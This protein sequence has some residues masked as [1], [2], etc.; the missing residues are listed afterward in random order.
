V[1]LGALRAAGGALFWLEV[2]PL[3]GGRTTLVRGTLDGDVRDVTPAGTN[4]RTLV[5][6]YG[7][8]AYTLHEHADG[9]VTVFYSEFSDQR[10]YRLEVGS[11]AAGGTAAGPPRPITPEPPR[12][13]GL[14][15]ADS[16]VSPDGRTLYCVRE[17]HEPESVVN[18][19]VA[20][21]TDGA[22]AATVVAG[23]HDFF[24]A[25]RLSPD[26]RRLAW[27][28]WDHPQMPWDGTELWVA[29]VTAAGDLAAERRVAG[30][31][32]ESVLQP[33]WSTDGRL[34]FV[35]DRSGW[36]NLY[37]ADGDGAELTRSA[38]AIAPAAAE[39]AGPSWVFGLQNYRFL[40][41]GRIVACF[42]REG[43]DR[44]CLIDASRTVTPVPSALTV[45][46]SLVV[47]GDHI[48]AVAGSP[49]R[50][51]AV[52]VMD[53][54]G[55]DVRELRRSTSADVDPGYFS[56]PQPIEFPTSYEPAAIDGPLAADPA[57]AGE[58]GEPAHTCAFT[59]HA[60]YY[61]P[62]NRD[63]RGPEH[64]RP[65]LIV[66]SHG[67]PTSAAGTMLSLS[68]QYWTSRGIAVVDVDYGGS[69]GYGRAYRERL[70]ANWGIV[71]TVD[72]IN[73]ARF[74]AA[75][76]DVDPA[77]MAVTGGSAGGYTT[78]NALTRHDVFAAGASYFGVADLEAFALGGTHKFEEQYLLGLI[79]PY[80]E[81]AATYVERSPINHV[82]DIACPVIL[83]QG[84][85]DAIV[86][87]E[88][89]EVI[90]E[91]LERNGLPYAYLAFP[92][93]QHGFRA[94]E[95]IVRSNEA[96][97]YF[98]GR[99]FGFTPADHI[100]PVEIKNLA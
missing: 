86:R 8:G 40:P 78:L 38:T 84:L 48:A 55:G 68:I 97:L 44:L 29:D 79:G 35:S 71:D 76:G 83:F 11:G 61:P 57:C 45:F 18:E 1:G 17:R 37:R 10:L 91:A 39:F 2:R 81:R 99:V 92:G 16:C 67:G 46:S 6:E 87:P 5:H 12:P 88:Q 95:N 20:L 43:A 96:E 63:F 32:S 22:G 13:R 77:R 14:R 49:A 21:G 24:A 15:Y 47:A 58:R 3:D 73:A 25:P 7:G 34:H 59:A 85:E 74:L 19:L 33:A 69:S 60:L 70:R 75:R 66:M 72:C 30:G 89:S 93:E 100:E 56:A 90:V 50:S 4:V 41:D 36:W 9:A 82:A 64:E 27:L 52:V 94:A 28:C 51:P 31:P 53:P 26:G 80:P 65:P 98:Y 23:G 42:H 62:A 54:A